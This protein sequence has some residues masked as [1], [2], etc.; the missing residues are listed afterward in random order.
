MLN[1]SSISFQKLGAGREN[2]DSTNSWLIGGFFRIRRENG[3][4]LHSASTLFFSQKK[5]WCFGA[6]PKTPAEWMER[7][8]NRLRTLSIKGAIYAVCRKGMERYII[9]NSLFGKL[10]LKNIDNAILKYSPL[11][12]LGVAPFLLAPLCTWLD[13]TN[14]KGIWSYLIPPHEI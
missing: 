6:Q 7:S 5:R 2:S 8:S 11:Q 10:H 4:V 13:S 3:L 9:S 1:F 14:T 12:H